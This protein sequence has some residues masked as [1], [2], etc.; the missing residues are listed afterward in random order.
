MLKL[1][2]LQIFDKYVIFRKIFWIINHLL[3]LC[4]SILTQ[5]FIFDWYEKLRKSKQGNTRAN[6]CLYRFREE[7]DWSFRKDHA[8]NN[9]R[10]TKTLT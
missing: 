3:T 1:Y 2:E 6:E 7:I 10:Y 4:L 8:A 5:H 9:M